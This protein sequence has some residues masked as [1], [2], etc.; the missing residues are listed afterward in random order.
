MTA[1]DDTPVPDYAG[2]L[3]LD[4]RRIVVMGAGQGIGRQTS[5]ALAAN[6]ARIVGVDVDENLAREVAE[7][8]GG[9]P[10]WGDATK[11]GEVERLFVDAERELDGV[12]GVV[13]IIGISRYHDLIDATDE[14]W[15]FHFDMCLR[16]AFLA[17]QYGGA[18]LRRAGGGTLTF[19]ASASGLTGAPR[20]A[21]YGAAKAG[22]MALVRS[23]AVEFGPHGIR[24]NAVAPGVVWTPRVSSYL[25]EEGKQRNS[26]N[27]PLDRVALPSN[28]AS[29]LLFLT[30][31]LA[32][33]VNGQVLTVDG[34]VSAK[35]PYPMDGL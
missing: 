3:R 35:F 12:D 10:W 8:I 21:I 14:E 18:A 30:S 17:M 25:G 29:A 23:A 4:G 28:I 31:P 13:D 20:H 26:A 9:V 19:V 11:R 1:T 16:H 34:G 15:D 6:G 24:T 32:D 22:L 7:E 5:H 27:T 33:Y 2:M